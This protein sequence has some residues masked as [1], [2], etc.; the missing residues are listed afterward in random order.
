[1]R[2]VTVAP[3]PMRPIAVAPQPRPAAHPKGGATTIV[4]D[5]PF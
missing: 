4:H 1:M 5:V 2:P 3:A